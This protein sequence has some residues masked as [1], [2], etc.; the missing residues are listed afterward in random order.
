VPDKASSINYL[1]LLPKSA[2]NN[3]RKWFLSPTGRLNLGFITEENLPLC[4]SHLTL[5]VPNWSMHQ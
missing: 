5:G 3:L 2:S 4:S 1:E